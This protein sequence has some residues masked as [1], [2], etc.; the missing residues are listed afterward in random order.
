MKHSST[1]TL[2]IV[3]GLI[4]IFLVGMIIYLLPI[5]QKKGGENI[6]IFIPY[7]ATK[8]QIIDTL[9]VKLGEKYAKSVMR[10]WSLLGGS[11]LDAHGSYVVFPDT[12]AYQLA[13]RLQNGRQ[14]PV[15]FTFNNVRTLDQLASKASSEMEFTSQEFITACDS[16]L[17]PM[18]FKS[19]A[20]Y[21]AAFLPDTYDFYWTTTPMKF[22]ERLA[23]YRNDFWSQDRRDKAKQ[24]GLTPVGVATIA[25]IVEEES[26]NISERPVIAR[27]YINRLKKG[28]KLQAD[29]TVKFAVG[30]FSLRRI[31]GQH[32]KKS[33]PYN[34]YLNLGLPPGPIRIPERLTLEQVLNAPE[35]EYLYMCAKPDFSG[36]HNFAVDGAQHKKNAEAYHKALTARGIK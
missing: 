1:F 22:V 14:T 8:N 30:D 23:S 5:L 4:L 34:T 28:M 7:E 11:Y 3:L 6:R 18:G 33:S 13:R 24:L 32:L 25:S 29:P 19:R 2:K 31:T 16:V 27:L 26:S 17:I 35:N 36:T 9:E 12:R 10:A 21:P 15:R 20:Q